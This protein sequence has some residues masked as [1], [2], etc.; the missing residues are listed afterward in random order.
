MYWVIPGSL[1]DMAQEQSMSNCPTLRPVNA[2][3]IAGWGQTLPPKALIKAFRISANCPLSFQRY[4]R[5]VLVRE[6]EASAGSWGTVASG[7]QVRCAMASRQSW[8]EGRPGHDMTLRELAESEL[9]AVSGG[10]EGTVAEGA[11][12]AG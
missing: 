1:Q 2:A 11:G 12:Q 7:R 9:L 3:S 10:L 8:S 6:L 5:N 4:A